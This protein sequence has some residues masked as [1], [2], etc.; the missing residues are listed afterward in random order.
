MTSKVI[1]SASCIFMAFDFLRCCE[2]RRE[3][4]SGSLPLRSA[5]QCGQRGARVE[6]FFRQ[7]GHRVIATLF[8]PVIGFLEVDAGLA[9]KTQ[10][11][12]VTTVWP[13][14]AGIIQTINHHGAAGFRVEQGAA[15]LIL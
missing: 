2:R 13:D 6:I 9:E 8:V 7:T 15:V 10:Q 3:A 12:F 5:W 1:A 14:M 4:S 11:A